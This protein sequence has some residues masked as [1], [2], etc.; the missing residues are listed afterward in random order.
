MRAMPRVSYLEAIPRPI[1]SSVSSVSFTVQTKPDSVSI[2][3]TRLAAFRR[4]TVLFEVQTAEAF[5][6]DDVLQF[7]DPEF[8]DRRNEV[9]FIREKLLQCLRPAVVPHTV[10]ANRNVGNVAVLRHPLNYSV[11]RTD[12]DSGPDLG[13]LWLRFLFRRGGP[14]FARCY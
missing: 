8:G 5:D 1:C 9:N 7:I 12:L 13:G 11:D 10:Q 14:T 2:I 4:A 3:L 6:S